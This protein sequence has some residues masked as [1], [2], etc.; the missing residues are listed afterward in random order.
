MLDFFS[1]RHFGHLYNSC[2]KTH[3]NSVHWPVLPDIL[4]E[5]V[6]FFSVISK[7]FRSIIKKSRF[8]VV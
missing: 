7:E 2:I 8:T 1:P 4:T 5:M 3:G 6:E